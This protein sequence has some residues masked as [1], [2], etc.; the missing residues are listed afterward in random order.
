MAEKFFF[1]I[2]VGN[3]MVVLY[4]RSAFEKLLPKNQVLNRGLIEIAWKIGEG[5]FRSERSIG[6]QVE[7]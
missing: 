7:R 3:V 4:L 5:N 2:C 1:N 6:L